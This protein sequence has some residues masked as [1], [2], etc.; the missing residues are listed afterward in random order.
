MDS[1]PYVCVYFTYALKVYECTV[2]HMMCLPTCLCVMLWLVCTYV[3]RFVRGVCD[4]MDGSCLLSHKVEKSKVCSL[5]SSTYLYIGGGGGVDL[6]IH[7]PP[8]ILG[9]CR[10]LFVPST[11][12]VCVAV[13]DVRICMSM[14][15]GTQTS[16]VTF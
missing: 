2:R 4:K 5:V 11:C 6:W 12:V 3:R 9:L 15:G 10:C 8:S 1:L 14:L 16:A 13:R 7:R